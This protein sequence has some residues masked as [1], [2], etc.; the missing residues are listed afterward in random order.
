LAN[1]VT[2]VAMEFTPDH[3][4]ATGKIGISAPDTILWAVTAAT[5]D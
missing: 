2:P 3:Y 4:P 5:D 1:P